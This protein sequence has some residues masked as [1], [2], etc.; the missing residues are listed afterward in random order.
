MFLL[1]YS[2]AE[3]FVVQNGRARYA[4]RFIAVSEFTHRDALEIKG[5]SE[6]GARDIPVRE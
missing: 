3:P 4:S 5:R 2:S 6:R 1:R